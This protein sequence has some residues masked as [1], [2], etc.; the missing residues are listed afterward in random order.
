M[1]QVLTAVTYHYVRPLGGTTSFRLWG[2]DLSDFETQLDYL[3]KEYHVVTPHQVLEAAQG[4]EELPDRACVL[5]FDDGLS[6][7]FLHVAPRLADR[8]W[9]GWFFVAADPVLNRRPLAVHLLQFVLASPAGGPGIARR[10]LDLVASHRPAYDIPD[11]DALIATYGAPNRFDTAE[12]TL[13]KRLLQWVLPPAVRM[14]V[15]SELFRREV[16]EDLDGFREELYLDR[17]QLTAMHRE[18]MVIGGHG[19]S[20]VWMSRIPAEELAAEV[21]GSAR[22]LGEIGAQNGGWALSWPYGDVAPGATDCLAKAGCRLAF[23][24]VPSVIQGFGAPFGLPRLD[25]N[26]LPPYRGNLPYR[27]S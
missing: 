3:G 8:G 2:R 16:T 4:R 9:A 11:D 6:D 10:V 21:E 22:M 20:H 15:L 23:S 14:A 25:T 12:V 19:S 26:D 17:A 7:H 1:K 27:M 13:V 5:T 18:G 24:T